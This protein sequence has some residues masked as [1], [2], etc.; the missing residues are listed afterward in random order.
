MIFVSIC[1]WIDKRTSLG[2]SIVAK[3]KKTNNNK[4]PCVCEYTVIH[5]L[6]LLHC[7]PPLPQPSTPAR[8]KA[9]CGALLC[10]NL[11]TY[12]SDKAK[13]T[14]GTNISIC[15]WN[16]L[17]SLKKSRCNSWQERRSDQPFRLRSAPNTMLKYAT[18][19]LSHNNF[20]KKNCLFKK[21]K[22][23][24]YFGKPHSYTPQKWIQGGGEAEKA[25]KQTDIRD[26]WI[27]DKGQG[28]L[29]CNQQ[30]CLASPSSTIA[31]NGFTTFCSYSGI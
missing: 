24:C 12:F 2:N 10:H 9:F 17:V 15:S 4:K 21:E 6:L 31:V 22:Y 26:S 3:Q 29:T 18:C 23:L 13:Q 8:E 27:E 7:L 14:A 28:L 11:Q 1:W 5:L 20:H 25:G 30:T 16:T 19:S